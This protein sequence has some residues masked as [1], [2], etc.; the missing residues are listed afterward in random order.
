VVVQMINEMS[1]VPVQLL[2]CGVEARPRPT[3]DPRF[4]ALLAGVVEDLCLARGLA[5]PAWVSEPDRFLDEWWF[6]GDRPAF[7]GWALA[8]APAALAIRGVFVPRESLESV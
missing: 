4:D 8:S 1:Q 2:A 7:E 3:G 6:V 5:P